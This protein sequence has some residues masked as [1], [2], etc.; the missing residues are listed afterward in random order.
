MVEDSFFTEIL[1]M[2]GGDCFGCE[3]TGAQPEMT[4]IG[5]LSVLADSPG[6]L[7]VKINDGLFTEY[8]SLVFGYRTIQ[9]GPAGEQTLIDI[10]G[11]WGISE[12]RGTD[13]PLGDLT[14]FLPGAFDIVLEDIIT[15][16]GGILP[17]GQV[18]YLV[19]TPTGETLGQL[20]CTGET[21]FDGHTNVCDFI[22]PTDAAEPLFLFYQLGPSTLS[23][24]YGRP[25]IAVGIAPGGEAVRLD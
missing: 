13:P 18:S 4:G 17:D 7:Q 20:V 15:A 14:E 11:R 3:P 12:N 16:D 5:Y 10:E 9:V 2:S 22:D 25:V 6:V 8:R 19:S 1:R 24:E 21:G 23:I